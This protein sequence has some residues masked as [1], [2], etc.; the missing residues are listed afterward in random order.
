MNIPIPTAALLA[1]TSLTA[2][3]SG[4]TDDAQ[5][6]AAA[7]EVSAAAA[8]G[9]P[10]AGAERAMDDAMAG[11]IGGDARQS[12]ALKM[13][14]PH[15]GAIAMSTMVLQQKPTADVAAMARRWFDS[16]NPEPLSSRL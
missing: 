13:I 5:S 15:E 6:E 4:Q 1:T 9:D 10:F 12:R 7:N 16:V 11:A 14:A 8:A 2:C 3:G